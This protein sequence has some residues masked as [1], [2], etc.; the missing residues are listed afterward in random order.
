M[1]KDS[2]IN[3]SADAVQS[4]NNTSRPIESALSQAYINT[5]G[6]LNPKKRGREEISGEDELVST[7]RASKK[8]R[9]N[10]TAI[11]SQDDEEYSIMNTCY[12]SQ[13]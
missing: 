12:P 11:C 4:A 3:N 13:V 9:S 8:R 7:V 5:N 6:R 1:N 10:D 2:Q